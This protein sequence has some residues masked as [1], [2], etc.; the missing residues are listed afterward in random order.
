MHTCGLGYARRRGRVS[1]PSY[2]NGPGRT[3]GFCVRYSGGASNPSLCLLTRF[4]RGRVARCRHSCV[5]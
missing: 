1:G 5:W 4:M 2:N 3:C